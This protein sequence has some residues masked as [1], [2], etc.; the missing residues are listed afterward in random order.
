MRYNLQLAEA[1]QKTTI[2]LDGII[3]ALTYP[4][5]PPPQNPKTV[6]TYQNSDVAEYLI[7]GELGRDSIPDVADAVKVDIGT[8][9]TSIRGAFEDCS[10][11]TSITIPNGVTNIGEYAFSECYGLTSITIPGS[12]TSI[13]DN[14]FHGCYGLTSITIP[15]S[16]MSIGNNAFNYCPGL[17][18]VMIGNG[19]TSI[20][21]QAFFNC[22][23]L[24][25]LIL[26]NSITSIGSIAFAE[27]IILSSIR[28][29]GKTIAEVQSM[30]NYSWYLNTGCTI[31]CTDGDITI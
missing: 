26:P 6:V 15:N 4:P 27:C 28:F 11:L 31:R 14:A 8:A 17:T 20:G 23:K 12:V 7:E 5:E 2:G 1:F 16:V 3:E 19:V 22:R 10:G 13:G 21:Y 25:S 18:S 9:V 24:T 30:S 29:D